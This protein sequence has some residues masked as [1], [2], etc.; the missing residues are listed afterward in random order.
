[1]EICNKLVFDIPSYHNFNLLQKE[2]QDWLVFSFPKK[3]MKIPKEQSQVVGRRKTDIQWPKRE[4]QGKTIIYKT[5]HRKLKINILR[6]MAELRQSETV[7]QRTDKIAM[8]R[9]RTMTCNL[10]HRKLKIEQH[11]EHVKLMV[12]RKG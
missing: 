12:L 2:K 5:L 1:M 10:L 8:K 9:K 11:E 7:S 4:K 6:T 3:I